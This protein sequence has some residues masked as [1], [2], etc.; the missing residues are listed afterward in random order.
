MN[1]SLAY[2]EAR[3]EP[4]LNSGCRLWTGAPGA[5]GYGVATWDGQNW[6]AHRFSWTVHN[7]TIPDGLNVLHSCDTPPCINPAHLFLGTQ[8][9]NIADMVAKDR[10]RGIQRFGA[11]SPVA[12]LTEHSVWVIRNVLDIGGITQ[13]EVARLWHVSPMTISRIARDISW[14]GVG[15]DWD[16][17]A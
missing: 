9:D 1:A 8:Q 4:E 12:V 16:R 13:R 5:G 17:A 6:K 14:P 3:S 15:L 7:G 11:D 10:Q 2:L